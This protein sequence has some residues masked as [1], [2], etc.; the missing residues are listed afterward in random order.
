M[1]Q[2]V[3]DLALSLQC[4]GSELPNAMGVARKKKKPKQTIISCQFLHSQEVNLSEM[5][6]KC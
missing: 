5:P 4:L 2:Q 6:N 1:A 3:K